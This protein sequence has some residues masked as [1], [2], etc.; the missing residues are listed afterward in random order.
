MLRD[1]RTQLR[2]L[3]ATAAAAATAATPGSSGKGQSWCASKDSGGA[4]NVDP[5]SSSSGS[6]RIG[7]R[8]GA[9]G[10]AGDKHSG[11]SAHKVSG[12]M[13]ED[14]GDVDTFE[15]Q[16]AVLDALVQETEK[17]C[18]DCGS[19]KGGDGGAFGG[20]GVTVAE[21]KIASPRIFYRICGEI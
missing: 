11:G 4:E 14:V 7:L 5:G 2:E 8:Q 20:G 18:V 13:G 12:S 19:C 3:K 21:R 15:G 1:Y 10:G 6:N 16:E 9:R 17:V